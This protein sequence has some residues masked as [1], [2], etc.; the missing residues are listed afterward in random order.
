MTEHQ[1][2]E[3]LRCPYCGGTLG[4]AD[5]AALVRQ[6]EHIESGVLGCDCCAFPVVAG[7]PVMQ[8]TDAT[9]VAIEALEAGRHEAALLG[10]LEVDE[11]NRA[12]VRGW[13]RDEGP[14]TFRAGVDGLS[15]DAE[16]VWAIF[17]VADPTSTNTEA[18][19]DALCSVPGTVRGPM[20]DMCG[21]FGHLSWWLRAR[22]RDTAICIGD[23]FFWKLWLA[24]RFLA[25]DAQ[26]VC[27]DGNA[28]LPFVR[29]AFP[30]V[31]LSDAFP[32]IW[33]KRMLAD[34]MIR[35]CGDEGLI[36]MPHLHSSLGDNHSAGMTLTP[37]AY[38]ALFA[39]MAPHFFREQA[40]LRQAV[41]GAGLDLSVDAS[42]EAV[43]DDAAPTM[44]AS[45]QAHVFRRYAPVE[46]PAVQGQLGFNPLYHVAAG[47]GGLHLRVVFPT[48]DYAEEFQLCLTYLPEALTL[49]ADILERARQQPTAPD[50]VALR[51]QRVLLDLPPRYC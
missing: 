51:R 50:I 11:A 21:G 8:A 24:G 34:E 43:G 49:P 18:L 33:H 38:A 22:L 32:Y 26:L 4:L 29:G 35:L 7:I 46:L 20:L 3:L 36:L 16:G 40:L 42:P 1:L 28:P 31:V 12:L 17:R 44:V 41:A 6:G 30:T 47:D 14:P 23:M 39:P 48:D 2:L 5:N 19:F 15:R 37:A 13:L 9:R 25:R 27:C 45:R 10:L